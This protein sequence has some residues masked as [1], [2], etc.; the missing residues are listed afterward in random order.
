[1]KNGPLEGLIGF[2]DEGKP[3]WYRN[4]RIVELPAEK[5]AP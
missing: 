1:M 2:H 5:S 3:V 4:V